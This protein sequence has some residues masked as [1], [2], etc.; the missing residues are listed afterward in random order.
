VG[1][2]LGAGG[3]RGCAHAGVIGVLRD[4]GVNIDY[5]IGASVGSIFGL[6]LAAALPTSYIQGVVRNNSAFEM[7][8]FYAGRLRADRRNPIARMVWDAG[9]GKRFED[10]PIAFAAMATDM[11][12][13]NPVAFTRG[14]IVPAIEA[15]IALPFIAKPAKIGGRYYVDGGVTDTAP[16]PVARKMGADVVIAVCLGFQFSA[17]S[18]VRNRTWTR[19][20]VE[21]MAAPGP[22]G[23]RLR[24]QIRFGCRL[25]TETYDV[26]PP[27]LDADVAIWPEFGTVRP[28][29]MRGAEY[30]LEQGIKAAEEALPRILEAVRGNGTA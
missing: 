17:P 30:C 21:R 5:V 23:P 27:A 19:N 8:R 29:R 14:P 1:L 15:S 3:V 2:V 18:F 9:G 7:L 4:A 25:F 11:E 10:L 28:N 16:V 22:A 12:T 26:P 13:G 24:D 6:G 20:L